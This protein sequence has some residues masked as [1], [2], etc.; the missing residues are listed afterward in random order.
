M[1]LLLPCLNLHLLWR[2]PVLVSYVELSVSLSLTHTLKMIYAYLYTHTYIQFQNSAYQ[3]NSP[4][5][6]GKSICDK[7]CFKSFM[8]TWSVPTSPSTS[9]YYATF[10]FFL[11]FCHNVFSFLGPFDMFSLLGIIFPL[12]LHLGY[13]YPTFRIQTNYCFYRLILYLSRQ[14]QVP[15]Y[16]FSQCLLHFLKSP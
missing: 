13:F 4:L 12:L 5:P 15:L 1:L 16:K 6:P 11:H 14:S 9:L 10:P 8:I 3:V 7:P 2:S